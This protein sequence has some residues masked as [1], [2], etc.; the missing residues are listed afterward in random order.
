MKPMWG[1]DHVVIKNIWDGIKFL[2]TKCYNGN[3][4]EWIYCPPT[5]LKKEH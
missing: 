4:I 5:N 2:Y 3:I 1:I